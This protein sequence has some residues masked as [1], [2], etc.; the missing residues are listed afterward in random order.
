MAQQTTYTVDYIINVV[1]ANG[2]KTIADWQAALN[3]LGGSIKMLDRLNKRITTLNKA[4]HNKSWKLTLNTAD[5]ERKISSLETRVAALRKSLAGMTGGAGGRGGRGG[6]IP[7]AGAAPRQFIKYGGS[8]Y[9]RGQQMPSNKTLGKGY[10]WSKSSI[11]VQ[12][13]NTRE[14]V[15]YN[16]LLAQQAKLQYRLSRAQ[17]AGHSN[18]QSKNFSKYS[19]LQTKLGRVNN[20]LGQLTT[21][22]VS[23]Y[24][25]SNI[26]A[27]FMSGSRGG[28]F[29]NGTRY[30][31]TPSNLGYKLFGPTPLP[32][33]GG[34]A[35]DMLKGMGIAYGIAGIGQAFSRIIQDATGY[36]NI[37]QTVE[38]ILKSHDTQD[39]FSGRFQ[40]MSDVIRQVGIQTKFK[41]TEVADAAKFLAMAGLGVD[42]I[43]TAITPIANIALVGDTDLG[44]TADLVTNIMTGYGMQS[45]QMRHAADVMTN[46]FTMTNTTLPEI[47]ES[48]K[49]AASLLNAGGVGFEE[50]TAGIGI[51]GDAGI[52]GSQAGTTLRTIMANIANPTNRQRK[53]WEELG[54]DRM[55]NGRVR[56]LTDIFE[57]LRNANLYVDDFYQLFHKTAAQGAVSLA[58]NVDK[59]NKVIEENFLSDGMAEQLAEAKKNTIQGLW[60]QLTSSF[61]DDGVTAF[62]DVQANIKVILKDITAWLQTDDAREKIKALF[63]AFMEF[64][65]LII[66]AS[67]YFYEFYE[68][69]GIFVKWLIKAQLYIWPFVKAFSVLKTTFLSAMA[70]GQI[71]AKIGLIGRAFGCLANTIGGTSASMLALKNLMLHG[72]TG[73]STPLLP[74]TSGNVIMPN[75]AKS[76][77]SLRDFG[78]NGKQFVH[79]PKQG[80]N[81]FG[82]SGM[83]QVVGIGVGGMAGAALGTYLG[84]QVGEVGSVGNML[85]TIG[86]G[87]GGMSLGAWLGSLSIAPW[88]GVAAAIGGV[89]WYMVDLKKKTT[90]CISAADE[91]AKKLRFEDGILTGE[92]VNGTMAYLDL[93]YNKEH[94]IT[95]EIEKRL[96]LRNQEKEQ[97]EGDKPPVPYTNE[98]VTSVMAQNEAL[99]GFFASQDDAWETIKKTLGQTA[100]PKYNE[101]T[102]NQHLVSAPLGLRRNGDKLETYLDPNGKN[103]FYS[104]AIGNGKYQ[105]LPLHRALDAAALYKQG[106]ANA[107]TIGNQY[108]ADAQRYWRTGAASDFVNLKNKWQS[109]IGRRIYRPSIWNR[110]TELVKTNSDNQNQWTLPYKQGIYDSTVAAFGGQSPLWD[111]VNTAYNTK[112]REDVLKAM[113]Y[114]FPGYNDLTKDLLPTYAYKGMSGLLQRFSFANGSYGKKDNKT[115]QWLPSLDVAQEAAAQIDELLKQ[116]NASP[117][118]AKTAL[119][120]DIQQLNFLKDITSAMIADWNR[121]TIVPKNL[122]SQATLNGVAYQYD[123]ATKRYMPTSSVYSNMMP[124][125]T[126]LTAG[127]FFQLY[128]KNPTQQSVN[129]AN[130]LTSFIPSLPTDS[131][132]DQQNMLAFTPNTAAYKSPVLASNVNS[133]AYRPPVNVYTDKPVAQGNQ[134]LA[135]NGVGTM[136]VNIN[137]H[138][139]TSN[140]IL[141]EVEN[142]FPL[143]L[144]GCVQSVFNTGIGTLIS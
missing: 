44:E 105:Q 94:D 25:R 111:A 88:I 66:N 5:A 77:T 87:I 131:I 122:P 75:G 101:A 27:P 73:G 95:Q 40:K 47:A 37:M 9:S 14:L 3:K 89:I 129:A 107:V 132:P 140:E 41:V 67:K 108:F 46:T 125:W 133:A 38:N 141:T 99:Y 64:G 127:Q 50:A 45:H 6:G 96:N 34:M 142:R 12:A 126:G 17:A 74:W 115:G 31:A 118:W 7:A 112:K 60:A 116:F 121:N 62:K 48:Y 32:N 136:N 13:F 114:L 110:D 30:K 33:N 24:S 106:Q 120:P 144:T 78:F 22:Y 86:G 72:I 79:Q 81:N 10:Q 68:H 97:T 123:A 84:S 143:M 51:L 49:Y 82:M 39:D 36:D 57:D 43:R 58:M 80:A 71:V 93:M 117:Q 42:D 85:A 104:W 2:V 63:N 21:G 119:A 102:A 98:T 92:N 19:Q 15:A 128:R 113:S 4:F 35:I 55:E 130:N 137:V 103:W 76:G 69:F 138:G 56:S 23:T 52:K 91:L 83:K 139:T 90:L 124:A 26:P 134:L 65:E 8:L 1:N 109:E 28:G 18:P 20:S 59:W 135:T 54:I 11:P 100:I 70:V 29:G 16:N 61:T 53:K